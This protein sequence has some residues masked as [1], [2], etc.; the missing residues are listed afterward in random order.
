[1]K[2]TNYYLFD[3]LD[4]DPALQQDEYLW[5]SYCPRSVEARDGAVYITVPYQ[6]QVRQNDMLADPSVPQREFTLI[7]KAYT[8]NI[9]DEIYPPKYATN[10]RG[11]YIYLD[12]ATDGVTIRNNWCPEERF[13]D[14]RPGPDVHWENNGPKATPNTDWLKSK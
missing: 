1:M 9:I 6:R 14:N 5:K 2:Q 12:E 4:F 3:F 8:H 7:I 10:L 13:G 11:F